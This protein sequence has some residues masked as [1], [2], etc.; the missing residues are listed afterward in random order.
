[1]QQPD[2]TDNIPSRD[3]TGHTTTQDARAAIIAEARRWIGATWH[4]QACIPY[5]AVDCGQLLIDVYVKCGLIE[6]PETLY[7]PRDW[8]LHRDGEQYLLDIVE[9][10]AHQVDAPLPGDVALWR[11][12]RVFSHAAIV[13]DWPTI[14][15]AN[16]DENVTV[17]DA[18]C[19]K[20]AQ[21][22]VRFYSIFGDR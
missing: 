1:M 12:G 5:Q 7:C 13:I 22:E 16:S 3:V 21:R 2:F 8:A 18:S 15:H 19:C 17:A 20:L 9:Q 4:H 10:Y 11:I 14:I 6:R